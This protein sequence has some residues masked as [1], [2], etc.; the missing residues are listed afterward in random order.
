MSYRLSY[1]CLIVVLQLP[2]IRFMVVQLISC[3]CQQQCTGR[4]FQ[5]YIMACKRITMSSAWFSFSIQSSSFVVM[6]M[7]AGVQ[8]RIRM[9][10]SMCVRIVLPNLACRPPQCVCMF[11]YVCVSAGVY[12]VLPSLV[13]VCTSCC[14]ASFVTTPNKFQ[15]LNSDRLEGRQAIAPPHP[16]FQC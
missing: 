7:C 2:Y 15:Y 13:N 12:V 8:G 11:A 6:L 1:S 9:R 16:K 10:A 4:W 5:I 14:Q 3:S